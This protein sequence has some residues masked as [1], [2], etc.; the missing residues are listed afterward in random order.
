VAR[1][2]GYGWAQYAHKKIEQA[3]GYTHL[4]GAMGYPGMTRKLQRRSFDSQM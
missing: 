1:K 4:K 3:A 2:V